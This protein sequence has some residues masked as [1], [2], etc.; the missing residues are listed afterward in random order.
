MLDKPLILLVP[1]ERFELP[2]PSLRIGELDFVGRGY[3][4]AAKVALHQVPTAIF[5]GVATQWRY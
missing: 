5:R 2:T 3:A 4:V 1:Q